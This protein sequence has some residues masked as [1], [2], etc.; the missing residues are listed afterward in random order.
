MKF[1]Y[2]V[3]FVICLIV[4]AVTFRA[5]PIHAEPVETCKPT[6]TK[7][8]FVDGQIKFNKYTPYKVCA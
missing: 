3:M 7:E 5:K 1:N 2:F 8:V 6:R 4:I